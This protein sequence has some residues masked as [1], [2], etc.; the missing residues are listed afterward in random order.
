MRDYGKIS[1]KF[2]TGS[3][4]K[5]LRKDPEAQIVALYLMTCTMSEM[6][7]VFQIPKLY[8]AH[9]TGLDMEGACKGLQSLIEKNFCMY[10][11]ESETVFV[12]EMAKFQIGE[13]LKVNDNQV[14]AVKKAFSAM[15][16]EFKA[17]FFERYSSAFHLTLESPLQAPP[18]P[19]TGTRAETRAG[20]G[21]DSVPIGTGGE[22]P[23]DKSPEDMA[24]TELWRA[25]KSLLS[26]QGMPKDQCGTFVGKLCKDYGDEI[27][28]EAVRSAVV[29]QP[30]DAAS[31]LKAACMAA[32]KEGGKS[33]IPWHA[34]DKGVED[35]GLILDPP[36]KPLPGEPF[37]V[38]KARVVAAV[39]N[40]G[41]APA[42]RISQA[43]AVVKDAPQTVKPDLTDALALLKRGRQ[44]DGQTV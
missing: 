16:G 28:I 27:V 15:T 6:T 18:K 12:Y 7:G 31:F 17:A 20:S 2:W 33:L 22:P 10:D 4:G 43:P 30:A 44:V 9:E 41:K 13:E 24:K 11:E 8:I 19:R 35:K 14:K 3:T 39:D 29:K 21:T 26:E 37:F 40:G 25:G 38:F 42:P 32:K 5:S 1:A 36:I 23:S 34:T